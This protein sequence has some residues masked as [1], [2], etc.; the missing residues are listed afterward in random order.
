MNSKLIIDLTVRATTIKL[1]EENTG[2]N[3]VDLS[4]TKSYTIFDVIPKDWNLKEIKYVKFLHIKGYHWNMKS[5][6]TMWED[7]S[8]S[9]IL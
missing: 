7:I 9:Y 4:Y 8:K 1:L 5:H 2:V 3:V 6:D